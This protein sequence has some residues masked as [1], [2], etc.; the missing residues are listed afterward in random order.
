MQP[1]STDETVEI[2]GGR[3]GIAEKWQDGVAAR[4]D[5]DATPRRSVSC[6]IVAWLHHGVGSS[7]SAEVC[8]GRRC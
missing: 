3:V 6:S 8:G 2:H 5:S 7:K 4:A 1:V